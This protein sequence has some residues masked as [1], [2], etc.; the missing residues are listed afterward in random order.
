[1]IQNFPFHPLTIQRHNQTHE[2]TPYDAGARQLNTT[3]Q[4]VFDEASSHL[5][6]IIIDPCQLTCKT[7]L[8]YETQHNPSN[9]PHSPP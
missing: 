5:L 4:H 7:K 2:T 3:H 8:L 1:M 6:D 9:L